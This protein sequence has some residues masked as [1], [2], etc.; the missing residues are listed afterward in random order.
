MTRTCR[1]VALACAGAES[2]RAARASSRVATTEVDV[3]AL[4]AIETCAVLPSR[5][6]LADLRTRHEGIAAGL[7]EEA[8]SFGRIPWAGAIAEVLV[9]QPGLPS[10]RIASLIASSA[11]GCNANWVECRLVGQLVVLEQAGLAEC[12]FEGSWRLVASSGLSTPLP[13]RCAPAVEERYAI[14][15]E[16][17]PEHRAFFRVD[18]VPGMSRIV[19]NSSHSIY[20]V[21]TDVLVLGGAAA[22]DSPGV[23]A[24]RR[25]CAN[26]LRDLI[27]GWA[28]YE[29]SEKTGARQD[30]AREARR[31][32][33]RAISEV[34]KER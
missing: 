32:W 21:L 24:D 20:G 27:V 34:A 3:E 12:D 28:V 30:R 31:N 7:F 9:K 10:T 5:D 13:L 6:Q 19:L 11:S 26:L 29:E 8:Y 16:Y 18:S 4:C 15:A 17:E 23:W 22:L 33:G 14:C 2:I 1:A 25:A